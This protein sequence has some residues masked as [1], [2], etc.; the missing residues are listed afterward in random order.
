MSRETPYKTLW[1]CLF[2]DLQIYCQYISCYSAAIKHLFEFHSKNTHFPSSPLRKDPGVKYSLKTHN[3]RL[4]IRPQSWQRKSS[5]SD[6]FCPIEPPGK[7]EPP[8]TPK[9]WFPILALGALA[10]WSCW[11]SLVNEVLKLLPVM[12]AVML[13]VPCFEGRMDSKLLVV[14]QI[15]SI[16]RH[17]L[18]ANFFT[19]TL[20]QF[21]LWST[22]Q[23]D[24]LQQKHIESCRVNCIANLSE[25]TPDTD[26]FLKT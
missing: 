13:A 8:Q 16:A 11:L 25:W 26:N 10:F 1:K 4:W 17:Q 2:S 7:R 19:A 24:L 3:C 5:L 9:R 21:S 22:G 18:L 6:R 14:Y 15:H 12:P 20:S 23:E